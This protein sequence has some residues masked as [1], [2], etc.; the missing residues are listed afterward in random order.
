MWD[1]RYRAGHY[2][3]GTRPNDFL[4]EHFHTLPKGK[5]LCPAEG[6]GRNSVFLAKHGYSV[7]AVD[8][9]AVGL[10]KAEKLAKKNGV[11]IQF[12]HQ[13][14]ATYDLGKN[15][16]DA[17]VSIFCHLP[18]KL[19]KDFHK[20]VVAGLKKN[21]VLL[22][23]AYTPDQLTHKTGG[24]PLKEMM[25]SKDLLIEELSGLRFTRLIELEREVIEGTLHFGM[26]AVVQAVALK[27]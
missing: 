20:R 24:P 7:T 22:L 10:K 2:I 16:W 8:S 5:I 26:G 25:M 15:R 23:E 3:F 13:D 11:D 27:K 18:E 1:E 4:K 6:E 17:V 9:S 12:V 14:L 19:R 21:G